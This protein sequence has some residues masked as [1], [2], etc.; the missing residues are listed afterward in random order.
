MMATILQFERRAPQL[1]AIPKATTAQIQ[2]DLASLEA[3]MEHVESMPQEL[4]VRLFQY[5]IARGLVCLR[6]LRGKVE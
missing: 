5:C 3:A 2:A 6:D 1:P 4:V